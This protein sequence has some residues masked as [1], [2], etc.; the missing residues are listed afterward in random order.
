MKIEAVAGDGT[1]WAA[2]GKARPV[3]KDD[4]QHNLTFELENGNKR[5]VCTDLKDPTC[6]EVLM[7]L[8]GDADVFVT[9]WR[10][11]ALAKMKLDY[12]ILK[13]QFPKLVYATATGY[14]DVGP[15]CDLPGYDFTAF[16]TRSGILGSLYEKGTQPMNLIPSMGDRAVGMCLCSGILAALFNAQ[17]TGRG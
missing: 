3:F 8:I 17:R 2:E 11:K 15:D 4:L 7:K 14:G 5:S 13:E 16:W 1:R 10:P 9:N 12:E 6:Y